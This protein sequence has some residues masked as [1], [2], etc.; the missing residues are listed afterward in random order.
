MIRQ[1]AISG[2]VWSTL[3]P[4]YL[5][6]DKPDRDRY[7]LRAGIVMA[8][9]GMALNT[10][11]VSGF[12]EA[13][14]LVYIWLTTDDRHEEEAANRRLSAYIDAFEFAEIREHT[15]DRLNEEADKMTEYL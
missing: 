13:R 7:L 5:S 9:E 1:P 11:R 10:A 3:R 15:R 6:L 14:G 8:R 12:D 2:Y 4:H